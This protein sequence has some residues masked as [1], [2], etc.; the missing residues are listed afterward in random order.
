M[1][2][3]QIDRR[4]IDYVYKFYGDDGTQESMGATMDQ[5]I[6]ATEILLAQYSDVEFDAFDKLRV[7]DILIR[8]FGLV[9]PKK[10]TKG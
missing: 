8:N 3:P 4:F 7:R 5:I 2:V 1:V 10:F 9:F 6:Q